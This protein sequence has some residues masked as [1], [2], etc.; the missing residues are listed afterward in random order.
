MTP[1]RSDVLTGSAWGVL[2][3]CLY[4]T[5]MLVW[6]HLTGSAPAPALGVAAYGV[7]L[8]AFTLGLVL[9]GHIRI[10]RVSRGHLPLLLLIGAVGFGV[11]CSLMAGLQ[12]STATKGAILVRTDT[13]FAAV[14]GALFLR[15]RFRPAALPGVVLMFAGALLS[16]KVSLRDLTWFQPADLFFFLSALCLGINAVLVKTRLRLLSRSTVAYYNIAV[17][18]ALFVG[19]AAL[20]GTARA[21]PRLL[22]DPSLAVFTVSA[23]LV[24]IAT[25]HSYYS[26]LRR[27]PAWMAR[28]FQLLVPPMVVPLSMVFLGESPTNAQVA[29]MVAVVLGALSVARVVYRE[30]DRRE[31]G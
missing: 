17:T 24:M 13:F 16:M 23:G 30:Q 6:K 3:A 10:V 15:E 26:V 22:T 20:T 31:P 8:L 9:S 12:F 5:I 29:G 4:S 25:Y 7:C 1:T 28:S 21:A 2:T 27:L 18:W 19:L 11:N 14:L